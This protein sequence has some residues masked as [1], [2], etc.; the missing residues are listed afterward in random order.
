[1]IVTR[2][3]LLRLEAD[4]RLPENRIRFR[5]IVYLY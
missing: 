5:L 3:R 1:M 2:I 4:A